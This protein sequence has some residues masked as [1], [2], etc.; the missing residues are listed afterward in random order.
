MQMILN[1]SNVVDVV[2]GCAT[3]W[4]MQYLEKRMPLV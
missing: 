2:V 1:R 3:N 4:C